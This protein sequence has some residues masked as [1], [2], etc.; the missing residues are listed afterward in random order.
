MHG[1]S[2]GC[3][4]HLHRLHA[5]LWGL[6]SRSWVGVQRLTHLGQL[7]IVQDRHQVWLWRRSGKIRHLRTQSSAPWEVCLLGLLAS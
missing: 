6:A 2:G 4:S 3:V 1:A 7:S 5:E